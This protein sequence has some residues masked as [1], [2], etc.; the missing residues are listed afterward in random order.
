MHTAIRTLVLLASVSLLLQVKS[1]PL[2]TSTSSI[3]LTSTATSTT[4]STSSVEDPAEAAYE[5]A[6]SSHFKELQ[7]YIETASTIPFSSPTPGLY[8]TMSGG[9][10]PRGIKIGEVCCYVSE[11]GLF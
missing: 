5:S 1:Q 3:S 11:W 10:C 7:S 8:F 9:G 4:R 2:A 6:F